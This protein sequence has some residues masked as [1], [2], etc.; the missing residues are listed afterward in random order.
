MLLCF[1]FVQ[2]GDLWDIDYGNKQ[3][4]KDAIEGC[5]AAACESP[6]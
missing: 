6:D 3:F 5:E 4:S 1:G 2:S